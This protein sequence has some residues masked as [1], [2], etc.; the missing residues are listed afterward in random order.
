MKKVIVSILAA[1]LVLSSFTGC[2]GQ[3]S[4]A[5]A[6]EGDNVIHLQLW[7]SIVEENGPAEVVE[8]FNSTHSDIQVEYVH[9]TN[10]DAG[11][12]KLDMSLM[13][14]GDADVFIS[15]DTNILQRRIDAGYTLALNDLMAGAGIEPVAAF[16]E[17][18]QQF[19]QNGSYYTLPVEISNDCILYNK[20]MFDDAGIPYPTVGWTYDEFIAAAEALTHDGIYGYYYP[21]WDSQPATEFAMRAMGKN[22]MY[23]ENGVNIDNPTLRASFEAYMDRME[24]GIE[25]DYVDNAT[26]KMNSQDMLL[27]GKAAMVFGSWIVR[28][29]NDTETYPHDFVTGFATLPKLSADQEHLYSTNFN[30]F[31]S[32]NSK[33]E[34]PEAAMEFVK[35]YAESGMAPMCKFGRIPAHTSFDRADVVKLAFG[36]HADLYD[37]DEVQQVYMGMFDVS[38][39][40]I[41]TAAAEINTILAEE[42]QKT[43]ADEQTV[44]EAIAKAQQRAQKQYEAAK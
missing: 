5:N 43:F 34:H 39:R 33:S 11:N 12:T 7:G 24:R 2:G 32:I 1:I 28:Y 3:K 42:F 6:N 17:G 13:S 16:G 18:V 44:D 41:T 9:Y 22:W 35:W 29:V 4:E 30:A 20:Q 27:Q 10:D 15:Y 36:E 31:M 19:Q 38:T 14:S 25:V 40:T 23:D 21:A 37:M 8:S 26:Q